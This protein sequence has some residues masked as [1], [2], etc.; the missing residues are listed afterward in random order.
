SRRASSEPSWAAA[1]SDHNRGTKDRD[2]EAASAIDEGKSG[3][4]LGGLRAGAPTRGNAGGSSGSDGSGRVMPRLRRSDRVGRGRI[5][6]EALEREPGIHDGFGPEDR[7][8]A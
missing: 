5:R 7:R 1:R 6:S 2:R 8:A 4:A 3:G